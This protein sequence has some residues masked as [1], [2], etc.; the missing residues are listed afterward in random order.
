[1]SPNPYR[2]FHYHA[3]AHAFSGH[4][5]RPFEHQID[6]QAGSVLPIIGGLADSYGIRT[7]LLL[8]SPVFVIGGLIL[9]SA[10]SMVKADV[11]RVWTTAAAQSEVAYE[12]QQNAW[13]DSIASGDKKCHVH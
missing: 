7:A 10:G 3:N 9:A 11:A 2:T 1:M 5:T 13:Q 8:A 12:R 4:F 6:V